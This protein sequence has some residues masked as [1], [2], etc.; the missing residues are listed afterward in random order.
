[1]AKGFSIKNTEQELADLEA[2]I[3]AEE[4]KLNPSI[5]PQEEA[6]KSPEEATFKK[7]YGD[8]RSFSQK[9]ENELTAKID[10]LQR[11]LNEATGNQ[12]KFPK[13]EDEV[14]EWAQKYPDVYDLV[15]TIARKNAIEVTKDLDTRMTAVSQR[16]LEAEQ[17][18]AQKKLLGAHPDFLE[19]KETEEFQAW[20][21]AQPTFVYNTLYESWDADAAIR[22][23]D[24]YKIDTGKK[25]PKKREETKEFATNPVPG[26]TGASRPEGNNELKWTE[27]K[28]AKTPWREQEKHIEEIEKAMQNPAFYDLSGGAR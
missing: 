18:E 9:R 19:L 27:S 21:E 1:M 4:E 23:V 24:L 8:L 6:P 7:R 2:R 16:E 22:V 5:E 20:V 10:A 3:K 14:S 11:Q 13:T 26:H 17:R 12:M 25:A 15:V 28:V